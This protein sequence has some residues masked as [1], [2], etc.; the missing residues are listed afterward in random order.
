MCN[1]RPIQQ[2]MEEC[3]VIERGGGHEWQATQHLPDDEFVAWYVYDNVR[4]WR[5]Y[6]KYH[7]SFPCIVCGEEVRSSEEYGSWAGGVYH[8]NPCMIEE[9][10]KR[11]LK[12][13]D[14]LYF[15]RLVR[16]FGGR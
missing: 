6:K 5:D 7:P 1:M 2:I 11:K 15:K 9:I 12:G 14:S 16:V 13:Y 4:W 8:T 3:D 10:G